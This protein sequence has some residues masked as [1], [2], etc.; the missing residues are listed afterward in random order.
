MVA[1]VEFCQG[2]ARQTRFAVPMLVDLNIHYRLLKLA[3]G[4]PNQAWDVGGLDRTPPLFGVWHPYK[5]VC[6]CVYRQFHS[7]FVYLSYGTVSPGDQFPAGPW[8]RSIELT[9]AAVLQCLDEVR[10]PLEG[11]VQFWQQ[12]V[13]EFTRTSKARS[14]T[15]STSSVYSCEYTSGS[16]SGAAQTGSGGDSAAHAGNAGREEAHRKLHLAQGLL[17]L[18]TEYIP[19]CLALGWGVRQCH[20]AS[21]KKGTAGVA[22][23]VLQNSLHVSLRLFH[24]REHTVEYVRSIV[25][26]LITWTDWHSILPGVCFFRGTHGGNVGEVVVPFAGEPTGDHC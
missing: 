9:M 4:R 5:Y 21:R 25:W 26:A 16:H 1:V 14:Q 8:L 18:C 17:R 11:C 3:Y 6:T 10:T 22:K 20:W 23:Q 19:A 24:G 15:S 2:V 13:H 7:F 12:K